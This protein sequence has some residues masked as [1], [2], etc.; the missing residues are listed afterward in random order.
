MEQKGTKVCEA[1]LI[2]DALLRLSG[3]EHS[4]SGEKSFDSIRFDS[5]YRID[6]FDSIRFINLINLPL[7]HDYLNSKVRVIFIV[8]LCIA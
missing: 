1:R 2:A 3:I 6:F 7:V 5:R 8:G 4:N